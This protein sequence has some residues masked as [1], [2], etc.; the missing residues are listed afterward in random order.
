M[1]IFNYK[2]HKDEY[3]LPRKTSMRTALTLRKYEETID[4]TGTHAC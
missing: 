1:Q 4:F 3:D 2:L